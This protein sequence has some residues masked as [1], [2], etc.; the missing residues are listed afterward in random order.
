MEDKNINLNNLN[1]PANLNEVQVN[2]DGNC[3][4]RSLSM[5]L[6]YNQ[7]NHFYYRNLVYKFIKQNKENLKHF[8][9]YLD[10]ESEENYQK[11]YN[12]FIEIIRLDGNYAGD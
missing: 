7:E 1:E 5:C 11:R 12:N 9:I 3:F 6:E 2:G 10:N 4:F 8:F